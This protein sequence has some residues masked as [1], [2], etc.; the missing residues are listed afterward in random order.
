MRNPVLSA[1]QLQNPSHY[2]PSP[3]SIHVFTGT[4]EMMGARMSFS[5]NEE[6]Y[7]EAK[8]ADYL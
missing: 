2:P 7:G 1:R 6:I 3:G 8:A 4:L 5:R